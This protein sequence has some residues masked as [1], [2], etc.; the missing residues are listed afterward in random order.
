MLCT[1]EYAPFV[2]KGCPMVLGGP[3]PHVMAAKAIAFAEARQPSFA[4]Y[5]SA[6]VANAQGLAE[7]LMRRGVRLVTGGP[8]TTWCWRTWPPASA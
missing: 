2:D 1:D 5:A 7:G 8:A 3:L 6:I 4:G